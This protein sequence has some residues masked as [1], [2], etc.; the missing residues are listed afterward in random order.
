MWPLLFNLCV[1]VFVFVRVSDYLS[2]YIVGGPQCLKLEIALQTV[3]QV[4]LKLSS[5]LDH[6]LKLWVGQQRPHRLQ[7]L[8]KGKR[9]IHLTHYI[10][11]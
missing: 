8:K 4:A 9:G 11:I 1:C 2:P 7:V 3:S 5:Q 6:T 10:Y